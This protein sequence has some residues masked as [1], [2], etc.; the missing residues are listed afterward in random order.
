[1]SCY[2]VMAM[3]LKINKIQ[4][5]G[6]LT[7]DKEIELGKYSLFYGYKKISKYLSIMSNTL[8]YKVLITKSRRLQIV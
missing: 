4:N 3:T 6:I 5:A 7:L 8:E 2:F 1:M